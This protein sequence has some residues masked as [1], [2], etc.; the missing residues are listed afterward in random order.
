MRIFQQAFFLLLNKHVSRFLLYLICL[1]Y[2]NFIGFLQKK[3][4][5]L[6]CSLN[7]D[8][9]QPILTIELITW[10]ISSSREPRLNRGENLWNF[11]F[12]EKIIKKNRFFYYLQLLRIGIFT[13]STFYNRTYISTTLIYTKKTLFTISN[14]V[15]CNKISF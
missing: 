6:C 9:R 5:Y 1:L 14:Y 7:L 4:L 3:K 15:I 2:T 8:S 10:A 12:Y 13:H 11:L